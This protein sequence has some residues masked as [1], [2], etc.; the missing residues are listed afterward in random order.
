MGTGT[1]RQK[2]G[3][4]VQ[5]ARAKLAAA[6]ELAVKRLKQLK[7]TSPESLEL[8][9]QSLSEAFKQRQPFSESL[10]MVA[11]AAA[12][13]ET[14]RPHGSRS[15]DAAS[16]FSDEV[17]AQAL[18]RQPEAIEWT[19]ADDLASQPVGDPPFAESG[20]TRH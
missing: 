19:E 6:K 4:R 13:E 8:L 14:E 12:P 16:S 9:V 11:F 15:G 1:S 3:E 5:N 10:L 7:Q 17:L 2:L 20:H 18:V